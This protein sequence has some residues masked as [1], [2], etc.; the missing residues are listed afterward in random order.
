MNDDSHIFCNIELR[1]DEE[2]SIKRF[3]GDYESP[4]D[5]FV[6]RQFDGEFLK[7]FIVEKMKK[8][9][10]NHLIKNRKDLEEMTPSRFGWW[11]ASEISIGVKQRLAF[12]NEHGT[13]A[14]LRAIIH[15]LDEKVATVSCRRCGSVISSMDKAFN[16]ETNLFHVNSHGVVHNILTVTEIQP[17]SVSLDPE[18]PT[19]EHSWFPGFGWTIMNCSRCSVHLGWLF[20]EQVEDEHTTP[21]EFYAFTRSQI[22]L[23]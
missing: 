1:Q 15:F 2:S 9:C 10:W 23:Q 8:S 6:I 7:S 5:P 14:R 4:F 21:K 12:L 19:T 18:P 11:I 22:K 13:S 20:T 3:C 17:N 16:P